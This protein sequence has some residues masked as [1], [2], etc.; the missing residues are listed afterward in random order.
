MAS[1]SRKRKRCVLSIEE[2]LSIIKKI[3][4]G[5]SLLSVATEFGVGKSTVYDI[6]ASRE[7]ITRFAT[8]TQRNA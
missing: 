8:E 6:K 1:T 2:K 7:K 3:D 4:Q 5:C